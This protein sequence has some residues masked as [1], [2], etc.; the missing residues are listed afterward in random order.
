MPRAVPYVLG[1]SALAAGAM[2]GFALMIVQ[3]NAF[4]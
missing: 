1:G 2:G 4:A 3:D